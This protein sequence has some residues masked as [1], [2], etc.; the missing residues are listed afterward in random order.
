MSLQRWLKYKSVSFECRP[1]A[2]IDFDAQI[3]TFETDLKQ[4]HCFVSRGCLLDLASETEPLL[5][6]R[7]LS[8]KQLILESRFAGCVLCLWAASTY[9]G[10]LNDFG[11]SELVIDENRYKKTRRS[12]LIVGGLVME[13]RVTGDRVTRD[14]RQ[15][16]RRL[17]DGAPQKR[18]SW[19]SYHETG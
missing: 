9:R 10:D 6:Q 4:K 8:D 15:H 18:D 11:R 16:D 3:D 5:F 19:A 7:I 17:R 2:R 1:S 13:D 12:S 14:W